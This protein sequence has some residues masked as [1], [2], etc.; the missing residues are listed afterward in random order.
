MWVCPSGRQSPEL[1]SQGCGTCGCLITLPG[2][3]IRTLSQTNNPPAYSGLLLPSL[4]TLAPFGKLAV[5][6]LLL[7]QQKIDF[8]LFNSKGLSFLSCPAQTSDFTF[9]CSVYLFQPFCPSPFQV[10]SSVTVQGLQN[11]PQTLY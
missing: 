6:K 7:F 3:L 5:G 1:C 2:L 4:F 10:S 9:I 11:L 8:S